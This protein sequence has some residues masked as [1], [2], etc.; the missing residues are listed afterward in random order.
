M[1][2]VRQAPAAAAG[3]A[4]KSDSGGRPATRSST[5]FG[6]SLAASLAAATAKDGA[7]S[8]AAASDAAP[9]ART[10]GGSVSS[11]F[12]RK[13]SGV[14]SGKSGHDSLSRRLLSERMQAC[15]GPTLSAW[16]A[17]L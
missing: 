9:L 7:P 15:S 8:L 3:A 4:A 5:M 6:R 2:H 12:T 16:V 14:S 11:S 17:L 10:A 1:V 13:V